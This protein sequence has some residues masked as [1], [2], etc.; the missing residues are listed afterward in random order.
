[1]FAISFGAGRTRTF[2]QTNSIA[3]NG[4]SKYGSLSV[5]HPLLRSNGTSLWLSGEVA[6]LKVNQ[7]ALGRLLQS[8]TLVTSSVGLNG[9]VKLGSGY[10]NGGIG[11]VR[12]L[13]G[14]GT[15][16]AGDPLSSRADGSARFLKLYG[17]A[18]WTGG[19]GH[20]F[21]L[22][23]AT[24]GQLA[25]RPLLAA[26]ELNVGGPGFGRGYDF[27]ERFGD[28]GILGLAELRRD[29]KDPLPLV[30]WAQLYG[31]VDGGHVDNL[32][33]G[34]G[35]GTRLSAGGGARLRA[36]PTEISLEAAAPLNASRADTGR[37]GPR[38]NLSI[39]LHF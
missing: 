3:I 8:D 22:K 38:I 21:S 10:L 24:S 34:F 30:H 14:F 5:S 26:Q 20:D 27:S 32:R 28:Q 1:V 4:H 29:F 16:R 9:Q 6:V 35:S 31:F 2:D 12:G 23:L 36:G 18:Q 33:A 11:A 19:L 25:S 7:N 39:G 17:W 37:K 13:G 15:T